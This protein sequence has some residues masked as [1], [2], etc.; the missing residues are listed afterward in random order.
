MLKKEVMRD[1]GKI[2]ATKT[3]LCRLVLVD[4]A[5]HKSSNHT[6]Y[7]PGNSRK[8]CTW[9]G[10]IPHCRDYGLA[11]VLGYIIPPQEK[12]S[13]MKLRCF[14]FIT[15]WS[16]QGMPS[17]KQTVLQGALS[18][19]YLSLTAHR[20]F[21]DSVMRK[22]HNIQNIASGSSV[23]I[24]TTTASKQGFWQQKQILVQVAHFPEIHTAE[25]I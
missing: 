18:T 5:S 1:W 15:Y 3:L 21:S 12:D 16:K 9:S 20:A 24:T 19:A 6:I 22:G 13:F 14:L 17:K 4:K 2:T 11:E 7:T 23:I 25:N 10:A 8:D